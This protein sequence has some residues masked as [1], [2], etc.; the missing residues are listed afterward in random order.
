MNTWRTEKEKRAKVG[1]LSDFGEVL[2]SKA[3]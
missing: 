2:D 1:D 3:V